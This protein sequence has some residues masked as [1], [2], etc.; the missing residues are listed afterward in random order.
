MPLDKY[1][2][3]ERE[4]RFLLAELPEGVS[5]PRRI[6]DRYLSGTRL[7]L[8]RIEDVSGNVEQ[9]KLGHKVRPDE[10]DP[11][12]ILHTSLYLSP[13]E[14]EILSWLRASELVKVRHRL[15]LDPR[16]A[17]DVFEGRLAGLILLEIDFE[18]VEA[19]TTYQPP[20]FAGPEVTGNEAFSGGAL[21][22]ANGPPSLLV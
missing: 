20:A 19:M 14:Y 11:S 22:H 6:V 15:D 7:R 21:A 16:A 13:D 12:L 10:T 3:P 9:L 18:S 2:R 4:R 17:V 1:S 5:D 8:R